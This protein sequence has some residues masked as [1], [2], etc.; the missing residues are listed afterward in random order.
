[1]KYFQK[2]DMKLLLNN[3]Y[4]IFNRKLYTVNINNFKKLLM[5]NKS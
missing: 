1:M 5:S 3:L 4:L 2:K